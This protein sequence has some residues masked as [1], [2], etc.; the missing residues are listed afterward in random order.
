MIED[1]QS[2]EEMETNHKMKPASYLQLFRYS[3]KTMTESIV[4]S[5]WKEEEHCYLYPIFSYKFG[6]T[7]VVYSLSKQIADDEKK[8][9]SA[10]RSKTDGERKNNKA[11]E[12]KSVK[13]TDTKSKL[14]SQKNSPY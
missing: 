14:G 4:S 6:D 7:F 3:F 9:Q 8:S 10:A 5:C 11:V 1:L 12:M 13:M 2:D